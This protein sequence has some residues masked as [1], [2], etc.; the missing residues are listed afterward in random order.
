MWLLPKAS[1][2]TILILFV[3]FS[4]LA[5]ANNGSRSLRQ[6]VPKYVRVPDAILAKHHLKRSLFNLN[7]QY[8]FFTGPDG[9]FVQGDGELVVP[10]KAFTDI[11]NA[12]IDRAKDGKVHLS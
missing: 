6:D 5:F 2:L 11:F 1:K 10:L 7:D 8:I 4:A 9:P 3:L 12:S